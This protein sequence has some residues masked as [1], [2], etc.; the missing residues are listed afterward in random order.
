[1]SDKSLTDVHYVVTE[2]LHIHPVDVELQYR[3]SWGR[4][5]DRTKLKLDEDWDGAVMEARGQFEKS[6]KQLK[7]GK[8][9]STWAIDL[10]E[11]SLGDTHIQ[12]KSKN[13]KKVCDNQTVVDN[14]N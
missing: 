10:F 8:T 9:P 6:Q 11:R 3:T 7:S 2:A 1:M 13:K 5:S 14:S 12:A 4:Q